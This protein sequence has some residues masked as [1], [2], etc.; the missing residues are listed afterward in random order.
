MFGSQVFLTERCHFPIA[1]SAVDQLTLNDALSSP[2]PLMKRLGYLDLLLISERDPARQGELFSLS[3]PGGHPHNWNATVSEVLTALESFT[4]GLNAAVC[5][6]N[7]ATNGPL[8]PSSPAAPKPKTETQQEIVS[9]LKPNSPLSPSLRLRNMS[10]YQAHDLNTSI[11]GNHPFLYASE[12]IPGKRTQEKDMVSASKQQVCALLSNSRMLDSSHNSFMLTIFFFQLF[13]GIQWIRR[14]PGINLLFGEMED[15][16]A[17]HLLLHS[18]HLSWG[19]QALAQLAAVSLKRDIYGVAQKDLP[20]ILKTLV[21]LKNVLERLPLQSH[22]RALK[23][24]SLDL[25]MKVALTSA[26]KRSLYILCCAFGPY[27]TDLPLSEDLR[28]ALGNYVMF[29][30]G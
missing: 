27:L 11:A 21:Q 18:Q 25:R 22:K 30:E 8:L 19:T 3:L 26:V 1:D 28:Q 5:D 14:K 10:L 15:A 20:A 24:G 12:N 23:V 16:Q 17:R 7:R 2:L 13:N 29:K 4:S 9:P 6:I